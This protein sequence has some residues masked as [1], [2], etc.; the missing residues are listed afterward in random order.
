MGSIAPEVWT[1]TPSTNNINEG[2][3]VTFTV[4]ATNA[5]NGTYYWYIDSNGSSPNLNQAD[6]TDNLVNGPFT[7][8]NGSATITR[9]LRNDLTTEGTEYKWF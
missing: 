8:T 7:L 3:T 5:A 9:Q 6:F 2:Q 4:T 1:I